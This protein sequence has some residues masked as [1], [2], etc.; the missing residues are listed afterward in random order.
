MSQRELPHPRIYNAL[1]W[2][3]MLWFILYAFIVVTTGAASDTG[4]AAFAGHLA[5]AAAPCALLA[6][7]KWI[8]IGRIIG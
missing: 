8:R 1:Y 7:Y 6:I 4:V 2:A 5:I 3:A